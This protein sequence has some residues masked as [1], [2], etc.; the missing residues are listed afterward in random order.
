MKISTLSTSLAVACLLALPMVLVAQEKHG[1]GQ[2]EEA[3]ERYDMPPA[4][5]MVPVYSPRMYSICDGFTSV[6]VNVNAQGLN[7][8]GDA[9]NEP[10]M[11]VDP[12][13]PNR[14]AVGWRQFN[15]VSSNF[16][17]GGYGFTTDGGLHWTFPG[18]IENNIF[19]SDP[20]L[21]S[22]SAGIFQYNSLQQTFFTDEFR[23]QNQGQ[24]WT[25]L[26]PATG[27]D[28]N[29]IT[30]DSTNSSG[31]GFVYQLWSTA[32]N[33][34]NGRQFSRSTNGG[35]TWMSPINIPNQPVWGTLDVGPNGELYLVGT[36]GGQP[37]L[38]F[39]RS[40]NAKNGGQTPSFDLSVFV[41]M[42]GDLIYGTIVNPDG[43]AGQAWIAADRGTSQYRGN[44]YIL[45]SVGVNG[46]NPCEVRLR[47][48]TD[49]G[50][51][52]GPV[53]RVND[54]PVNQGR[55]HWFGTLSVAPNGRV[56]AC[57][58]DT[59]NDPSSATSQLF[60]SYSLDGGA[61]FAPSIRVSNAFNSTIGWP[62]QQKIGDYMA[63]S[64]DNNGVNI[65]Y[66]ATFN[67]E[68]DIYFVRV[69][70][71]PQ[72]VLPNSLTFER[73]SLVSGQLSDLFTADANYVVGKPGITFGPNEAPLQMSLTATSP[74]LVPSDMSFKIVS[75]A[76][77]QTIQQQVGLF[78]YQTNAYE[79][80][81]T[82]PSTLSDQ[83][84]V[85]N[86]SGDRSRFVNQADGTMKVKLSY[87]VTG[88]T[89]GPWTASVNQTVWTVTP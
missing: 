65:T 74:F 58:F 27:G 81:D 40:L 60:Y 69:A 24:T 61:S 63:M 47:R 37:S 54:D 73:G 29:W 55:Y 51:T 32:G 16:R 38:R 76:S 87:K 43:L 66:P 14:I 59:R 25:K 50:A 56:D 15:S 78:N 1:K 79:T 68:Q 20:V 49:G 5:P 64:S 85:V 77:S 34:Y 9:A 39:V 89:F 57:W 28:K 31:S 52:W 45:A 62:Q 33:N 88:P 84:V 42:G 21:A 48:S 2:D 46:S 71:T 23:S 82:R 12:T 67:G 83:T 18:L 7:I 26:G 86:T 80:L 3:M 17:Q 11:V 70:V 35:S 8:V 53:V 75:K 10:S 44:I 6:Q 72:T 4:P 13:N 30:V 22:D 19:R 36:D 41:D